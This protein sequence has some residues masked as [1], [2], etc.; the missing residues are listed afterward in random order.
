MLLKAQRCVVPSTKPHPLLAGQAA[1]ME[2]K[3]GSV[4][5]DL[6]FCAELQSCLQGKLDALAAQ[7]GAVPSAPEASLQWRGAT[8]VVGN[9]QIQAALQAALES[10]QKQSSGDKATSAFGSLKAALAELLRIPPGEGLMGRQRCL[11]GI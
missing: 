4:P 2:A 7:Q 6:E 10:Q 9:P 11:K 1:C 3:P 5:S 8:Y